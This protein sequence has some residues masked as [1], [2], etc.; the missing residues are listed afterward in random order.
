MLRPFP[1]EVMTARLADPRVNRAGSR[2]RSARGWGSRVTRSG[3]PAS[4]R[5][6]AGEG[7]EGRPNPTSTAPVPVPAGWMHKL[8]RPPGAGQRAVR[9]GQSGRVW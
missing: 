9:P 4:G 3:P 7:M 5:S 6:D 2:G 8:T 1:A